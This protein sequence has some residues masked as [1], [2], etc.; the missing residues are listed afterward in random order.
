MHDYSQDAV[1]FIPLSE[2]GRVP[3]AVC[4]GAVR[5]VCRL[6]PPNRVETEW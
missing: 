2:R 6:P 5:G 1:K 3:S 4:G